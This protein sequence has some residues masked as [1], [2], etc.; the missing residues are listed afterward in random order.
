[1]T[2]ENPGRRNTPIFAIAAVAGALIVLAVT[3]LAALAMGGMMDGC[4]GMGCHGRSGSQTPAVL[5]GNEVTIE[6]KDFDFSPRD[7]TIDRGAKVTWVNR[8][9]A[10]HDATDNNDAW[11]TEVLEDGEN[12]AVTFET[13]GVF[14]YHCTI[15]PYMKGRLTVRE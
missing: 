4:G 6:I 10:P 15:H 13:P 1:V 11:A 7:A 5:G 12:G 8:D 9:A 3:A 2:A 14:E